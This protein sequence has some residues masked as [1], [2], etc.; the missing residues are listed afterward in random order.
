M[1]KAKQAKVTS[2]VPSTEPQ[3][4]LSIWRVLLALL[5]L[6]GLAAG[7]IFGM[8]QYKASKP[9]TSR[10]PWFAGYVDVT[11][12]PTFAFE[13]LGTSTTKEAVLSFIVSLP[14]DPCTPSWGGAYTMDKAGGALDLDRRI[15]RLQ[16]QDGNVT[17]SFGGLIN[18]E[19]ALKCTDHAKLKAAYR[20][21]VERYDLDTI[22]LDIEKDELANKESGERRAKAI[23]ELQKERRAD[24]KKLA[25]W[26]TLP[27]A[28]QGMTKD[29]TDAIA[30]LLKGGVDLAGVNVMTMDYGQSRE[31][32]VGMLEASTKALVQTHRQLDILYELAGVYLNDATIWSKI[33]AT[34]MIGQN[35]FADEVFTLEDAKGLNEF[36]RSHKIGRMSMWS[37]N[38]DRPCGS[39]YVDVKVVSDSCSGI[40]QD[41]QGFATLLSLGFEGSMSQSAG[42]VTKQDSA[43]AQHKKDDPATSPYQIWSESG[44]YLAGTKVV[45]RQNVYQAKWW[46][47]GDTPDNPVLQS[48]ETPWE[49]VGPVLQGE[50]PIPQATLPAGTYPEWSG[51]AEYDTGQ[52]VLFKGVPYQA[53][54]WN[55]GAS[56]AA[57][58]SNADASPWAPLTQAQIND[59]EA[60]K[61]N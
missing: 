14:S 49:L 19:L 32:G 1:K 42:V 5:L 15:A 26:I 17:V 2:K 16:Q 43:P 4:R 40:A 37:A 57:A 30:Q 31:K 6:A 54:W 56:P 41:K 7:G 9:A 61:T 53:K 47:Q 55:K 27:V 34:P 48:W 60:K 51:T 21:V 22:D 44:A 35:D 3:R 13:Q 39:N 46:T 10:K 52:R 25:V 24:G 50:K 33:G 20:S 23:A 45:W 38:R 8:D 12:T 58:S 59:I 28:P 29:G 36:A 18:D 11:A